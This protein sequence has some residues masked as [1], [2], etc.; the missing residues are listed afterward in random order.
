M[1]AAI[2][3]IKKSKPQKSK[4]DQKKLK[5]IKNETKVSCYEE[6]KKKNGIIKIYHSNKSIIQIHLQSVSLS[7]TVQKVSLRSTIKSVIQIHFI[8]GII[9]IYQSIKRVSLRSTLKKT[10]GVIKIHHKTKVSFRS[11]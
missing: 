10:V 11:I 9:Q 1:Q 8:N 4:V 7:S 2:C 3:V 6:I 5:T